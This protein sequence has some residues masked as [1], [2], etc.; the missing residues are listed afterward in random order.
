MF[1]P[2]L[3]KYETQ[4]GRA[5]SKSPDVV[6]RYT[7]PLVFEPGES[8]TY[9]TGIDWA[10][11]LVERLAKTTLEEFMKENIWKPLSITSMTFFPQKQPE[12]EKRMPQI[13]ARGPDG[14]LV[15]YPDPFINEG[16]VAC[17]GGQGIY[18]SMPDYLAF[19]L[20]I[21]RNDGKILPSALV[22]DVFTPQLRGAASD[23]IWNR[24]QSPMGNSA[25]GEIRP[26]IKFNWGLGG[27]LFTEDDVGRR[28]KGT[29]IWGGLTN[30]FW[31]ID[32]EAGLALAF[33]T[34]LLPPGDKRCEVVIS[35]VERA[36][37][38]LAG[39]YGSEAGGRLD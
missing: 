37:N 36:V 5:Y 21:L 39:V 2:T 22:D 6:S 31:S 35:E 1:D 29:M 33:G 19:Q 34:Q 18:S 3:A 9:G 4:R 24:L 26:D 30:C 25:A 13:S 20:S 17:F 23:A 12:L 38:A 28:K 16:N 7:Q 8:W 32:R 27:L 15:P 11:L 10:G 14:K